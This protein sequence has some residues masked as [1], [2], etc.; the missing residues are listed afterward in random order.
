[1]AKTDL[2]AIVAEY[3]QRYEPLI[4]VEEA[5]KMPTFRPPRSTPGPLPDAWM[6]SNSAAGGES[7]FIGMPS[8][9]SCWAAPRGEAID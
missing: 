2:D 6:S 9:G 5:A 8:C 1:M 4:Q 7:C 3:A